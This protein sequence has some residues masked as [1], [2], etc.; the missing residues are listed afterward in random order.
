M[1]YAESNGIQIYYEI[2]G[3]GSPLVIIQ[4]M[5]VEISTTERVNRELGRTFQVI[6]FDSR[7]TGRTDR[8]D[9][10]YTI[11]MMVRDTIGLL[12][13]LGIRKADLLGA[14]MGSMIA[15]A[16]AAEYPERVNRLVLHVGFHRVAEPLR[17]TWKIMWGTSWGRKKLVAASGMLFAQ[18][19][20]P[21]VESFRRQGEAPLSFD[22]RDLLPRIRCPVLILNGSK[23]QVVPMKITRELAE[24]IRG[25]E[26]ILTEGDHLYAARD[27]DLLINPVRDFLL[28]DPGTDRIGMGR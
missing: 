20:P 19:Y 17:T 3:E 18:K 4:G 28:M 7:G 23:D 25:A 27:P 26:L 21:S 9:T 15:L 13:H 6:A 12:D 8:P 11:D 5:G 1:P 24:G 16:I 14:S 22:G 10:P 2:H